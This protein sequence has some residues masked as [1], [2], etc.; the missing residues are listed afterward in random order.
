MLWDGMQAWQPCVFYTHGMLCAQP[1][2]DA[3]CQNGRSFIAF[4]EL[5]I[6]WLDD[7]F[8]LS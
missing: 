1:I 2:I 4:S 5:V 7:V 8:G 6:A 3:S